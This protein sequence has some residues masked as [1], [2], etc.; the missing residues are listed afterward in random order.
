MCQADIVPAATDS[1]EE[2]IVA[3]TSRK[4]SFQYAVVSAIIK[5]IS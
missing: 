3:W 2:L 4:K 1:L 5:Y